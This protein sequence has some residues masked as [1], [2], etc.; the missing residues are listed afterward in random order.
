MVPRII[1]LGQIRLANMQRQQ[2]SFLTTMFMPTTRTGGEGASHPETMSCM[3]EISYLIHS[4]TIQRKWFSE[5][6][7]QKKSHVFVSR[8]RKTMRLVLASVNLPGQWT[9]QDWEKSTLFFSRGLHFSDSVNL[10]SAFLEVSP[11]VCC[12]FMTTSEPCCLFCHLRLFLFCSPFKLVAAATKLWLQVFF[13]L[14][15]KTKKKP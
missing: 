1:L 10:K 5:S 7:R 4:K 13:H 12:R 8:S 2:K 9:P 3:V 14:A 15:L 6:T 11:G